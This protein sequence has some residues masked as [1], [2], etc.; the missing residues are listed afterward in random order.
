LPR[1]P[2]YG[3]PA[4]GPSVQTKQNE[5]IF[6]FSPQGMFSFDIVH[7]MYNYK[8]SVLEIL[9]H[10]CGVAAAVVFHLA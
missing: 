9:H 7:L 6:Y 10:C 5:A 3:E 8:I 4:I 1:S 2:G